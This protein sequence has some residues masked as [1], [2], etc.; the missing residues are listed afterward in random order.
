MHHLPGKRGCPGQIGLWVSRRFTKT[1]ALHISLEILIFSRGRRIFTWRQHVQRVLEAEAVDAIGHLHHCDRV[2]WHVSVLDGAQIRAQSHAAL[3]LKLA[4]VVVGFA[5]NIS[6]VGLAA[7]IKLRHLAVL[8][9]QKSAPARRTPRLKTPL[10]GSTTT[11]S[12]FQ[13]NTSVQ[14]FSAASGATVQ[15]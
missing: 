2:N 11:P 8:G 7:K 12:N 15:P 14:R 4:I 13:S 10:T 3:L 5:A 6:A 9:R 1:I